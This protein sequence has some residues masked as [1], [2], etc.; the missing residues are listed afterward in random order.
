MA[1][2][3]MQPTRPKIHGT[4][5]DISFG[6]SQSNDNDVVAPSNIINQSQ[7]TQATNASSDTPKNQQT[8]TSNSH[9][10]QVINP[11][12]QTAPISG[13]DYVLQE[14]KKDLE[15]HHS[16]TH[17]DSKETGD[18]RETITQPQNTKS[19]KGDQEE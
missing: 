14:H 1:S 7:I 8:F 13:R 11:P 12:T 18:L 15:S 17:T 19:N 6:T 4:I 9:Q 10:E 2:I 16:V 3:T 5:N